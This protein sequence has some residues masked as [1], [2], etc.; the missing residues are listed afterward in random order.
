M[1]TNLTFSFHSSTISQ[2]LDALAIPCAGL[3][4]P[5]FLIIIFFS[6]FPRPCTI[7]YFH[8]PLH[9]RNS[10][11]DSFYILSLRFPVG[12]RFGSY[13]PVLS[14]HPPPLRG[15]WHRCCQGSVE[16]ERDGRGRRDCW[17]WELAVVVGWKLWEIAI[18]ESGIP[19]TWSGAIVSVWLCA[20]EADKFRDIVVVNKRKF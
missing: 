10:F 17:W 20:Y 9:P 8:S 16:G 3:V 13:H 7:V 5:T 1:V 4:L 15:F 6:L 18:V 12:Y 19:A 2:S 11:H 14:F